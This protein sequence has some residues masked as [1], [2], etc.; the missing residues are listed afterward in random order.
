MTDIDKA[1][2]TAVKTG[3]VSFGAN[4][5][6]KSAKLGRAKVIIVASNCQR[7]IMD[8]IAYYSKLSDIP[9]IIYKGSSIDLGITCGKPFM[10]SAMT[11]R[12]TGDSDILTLTE[13]TSESVEEQKI[14]AVDE[15]DA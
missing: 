4:N 9:V 15:T 6:I 14:E 12:E 2:S 5:A 3:R 11:I 7:N 8:D 13:V 1:I 10:V